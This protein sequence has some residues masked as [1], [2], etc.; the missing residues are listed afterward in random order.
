M[1]Y[2]EN[3]EKNLIHHGSNC[4]HPLR[5]W[6]KKN[7]SL[8]NLTFQFAILNLFVQLIIMDKLK[9]LSSKINQLQEIIDR[10]MPDAEAGCDWSR[11]LIINAE[12]EKDILQDQLDAFALWYAMLV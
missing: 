11:S 6:L 7:T 4:Y 5:R 12:S 1:I 3:G 2:A 8:K 9:L 10:E